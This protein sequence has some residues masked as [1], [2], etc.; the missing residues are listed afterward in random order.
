M[1]E[2]KQ[3]FGVNL[4]RI[5][6]R[7]G[8]TQEVLAEKIGINQ[9]QMTRIET[10]R[11]FPSFITL[12]N[13]CNVLNLSAVEL[14]DFSNYCEV[15][16]NGT[17]DKV[18]YIASIKEN[19][20]ISLTQKIEDKNKSLKSDNIP[21]IPNESYIE[22]EVTSEEH[23]FQIAKNINR[24]IMVEYYK[25]S[26]FI[27]KVTYNPKGTSSIEINTSKNEQLVNE[28]INNINDLKLSP[29][30]LKFIKL[31]IKC[32]EDKSLIEKMQNVLEGM[33]L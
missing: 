16:K 14:F 21:N 33:L 26:E 3:Y 22:H 10:G 29:A 19:N 28:I 6:N 24:P 30:K 23:M 2:I 13:I 1:N 9:R 17:N 8:Y 20:V 31:A 18:H 12:D 5:R 27:K 25:N 15:R 4:K 7:Y 11:S 32:L